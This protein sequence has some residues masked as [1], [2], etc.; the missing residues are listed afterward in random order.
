MCW[1]PYFIVACTQIFKLLDYSS[2]TVYKASFSLAMANSMMNPII[3]A[4]KN[5]NF[6]RAFC[7]LLKC[8]SPDSQEPN[9]SVRSNVHRKS[10]CMAPTHAGTLGENGTRRESSYRNGGTSIVVGGGTTP[11]P[12]IS[13]L[14]QCS[15]E[16]R[17]SSLDGGGRDSFDDGVVI[18]IK[19]NR[20][21]EFN[22]NLN[23]TSS[24]DRKNKFKNMQSL[25]VQSNDDVTSNHTTVLSFS[26]D[27]E[28][29]D[30]TT[31][32]RFLP[33]EPPPIIKHPPHINS[34]NLN[35]N[36]IL[37]NNNNNICTLT[38]ANNLNNS[39]GNILINKCAVFENLENLTNHKENQISANNG[40][41]A[42]TLSLSANST[43][44]DCLGLAKPT[45][46][47]L[48]KNKSVECVINRNKDTVIGKI[49]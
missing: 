29:E 12:R 21:F 31:P 5:S 35:N 24:S 19:N 1:M 38:N 32:K 7:R 44:L 23:S 27:T 34:D 14:R 20:V 39:T 45:S 9:N 40:K 13:G 36:Y 33:E 8:R 10:S 28:S 30:N 25:S 22:N 43:A 41:S 17:E 3:Y 26:H 49:V 46:F 15:L 11:N 18:V 6:R 16:S 4:W 42:M 48:F 47:D 2:P 37:S